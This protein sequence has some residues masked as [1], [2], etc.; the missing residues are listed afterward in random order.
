MT[1]AQ[2]A[3]IAR[4]QLAQVDRIESARLVIA[5]QAAKPTLA[6][7]SLVIGRRGALPSRLHVLVD[8]ASGAVLS[9]R[10]EVQE[11]PARAGST[12]RRR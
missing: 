11:A 10:D 8:A 3:D 2:A 5:A 1:S 12:G 7:E 4:R 9:T 6:Y